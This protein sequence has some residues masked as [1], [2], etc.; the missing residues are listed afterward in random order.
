M[1]FP[2]RSSGR[3]LIGSYAVCA[4]VFGPSSELIPT[5]ITTK[6]A[7]ALHRQDG[8]TGYVCSFRSSR[9]SNSLNVRPSLFEWECTL[10]SGLLLQQ[11]LPAAWETA[12]SR[13]AHPSS[14]QASTSTTLLLAGPFAGTFGASI[15]SAVDASTPLTIQG[16]FEHLQNLLAAMV[17]LALQ[18]T[19]L[20]ASGWRRLWR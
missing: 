16:C 18:P 3:V 15:I 11:W 1:D 12:H 8:I 20:E 9:S 5:A 7:S 17:S 13:I 14:M 19:L 2:P 4:C 10:A 6:L